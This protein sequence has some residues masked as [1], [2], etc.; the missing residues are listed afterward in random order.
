[1]ARAEK[2][3]KSLEKRLAAMTKQIDKRRSACLADHGQKIKRLERRLIAVDRDLGKLQTQ[4]QQG[5]TRQLASIQAAFVSRELAGAHITVH[6]IPGIGAK[7]VI[8]LNAAGIRSA[9]DFNGIAVQA[10]VG[11]TNALLF[12][13]SN[14]RLVRIPGIGAGKGNAIEAWRQQQIADAN[15]RAP[16]T[17]PSSDLIAINSSFSARE[18]ELNDRRRRI[19][20]ELATG[21][22]AL[23]DEFS[24]NLA[25]IEADRQDAESKLAAERQ[26]VNAKLTDR[27]TEARSCIRTAE[28]LAAQ[29]SVLGKLTFA[30]FAW[31]AV[32]GREM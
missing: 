21:R 24:S 15:A 25:A 11:Y 32:R 6:Q 2:Q 12:R 4:K 30:R 8:S 31:S 18:R 22:A 27:Q 16:K 9:A 20:D 7:N 23:D 10:D 29:I 17:L 28:D 26:K 3:K 5:I 13:L 1:M 14:G 19:E